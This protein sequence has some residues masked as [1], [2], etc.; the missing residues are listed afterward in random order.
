[1]GDWLPP[2]IQRWS[3]KR[4]NLYMRAEKLSISGFRIILYSIPARVALSMSV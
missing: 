3:F 4:A 1:V 2:E